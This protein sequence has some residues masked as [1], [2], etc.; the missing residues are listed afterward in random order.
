MKFVSSWLIAMSLAACADSGES[1]AIPEHATWPSIQF[2]GE[3]PGH[4]NTIRVVFIND[5]AQQFS[6]G[7]YPEGSI[8]INEVHTPC[9][10]AWHDYGI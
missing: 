5:V 8:L 6:G 4:G 10:G 3:V 1:I 9:A 2:T 7:Q